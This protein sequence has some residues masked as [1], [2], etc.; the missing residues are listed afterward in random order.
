[1]QHQCSVITDRCI[2]APGDKSNDL[3]SRKIDTSFFTKRDGKECLI[4]AVVTGD[5]D[6]KYWLSDGLGADIVAAKQHANKALRSAVRAKVADWSVEPDMMPDEKKPYSYDFA[7]V[8]RRNMDVFL[9]FFQ[10]E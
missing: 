3:V 6:C 9:S 10:P 7:E 1:M 2:N 4:L 8:R 5:I